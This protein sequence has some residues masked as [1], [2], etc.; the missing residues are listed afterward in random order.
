M[1][2][3]LLQGIGLG[4]GAGTAFGALHN[5]LLSVTIHRGWRY[6]LLIVIT[7]LLT[8]APIILLMLFVLDRLPEGAQRVIPIIGG[9]FLLWLAWG[10]WQQFRNPPELQA[11]EATAQNLSLS[12]LV[13][14]M[15]VNLLNPAPYIYWG[16][17]GGALLR[18]GFAVS[19]TNGIGFLI[20]FYAA[21][22]GIMTAFVFLFDRLRH[23]DLRITRGLSLI[24]VLI[25]ALLGFQFIWQGVQGG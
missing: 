14:G 17:V 7:P 3:T 24:S 1:L 4:F 8:D 13:K 18:E 22:L 23:V 25:M 6:G 10:A 20:A 5:L 2:E 16:T 15:G 21:F 19:V 12:T 9:F 11:E